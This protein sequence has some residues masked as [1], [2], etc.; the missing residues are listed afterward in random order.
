MRRLLVISFLFFGGWAEAQTL[1]QKLSAA[2]NRLQADSQCSYASVSLT[3]LDAKTGEQVFTGNP[4]MGLATASTLKTITSITAFNMLGPDFQYQTLL[5]YTGELGADGTLNGDIIIK[6]AG[7]PTLGSWRYE[8]T[9]ENRVLATMAQ[10]L[11]KAGIKKITGRIIGDDSLFGTQSIPEGWIWQDIGNYYGA[12]TSGLCWRENQFDIKLRT[13]AVGNPV[14]I[15]R[16]VPSVP[17]LTFKSELTNG[18]AG[19][20]DNAY[21]FLPV[22]SK[23]MYLRG[24]YAIDQD[25]KSISAALPDAAYDAALR[26]NDTL[27]SLGIII[28]AGP[29][30]AVTLSAKNQSVP[31]IAKNLATISSPTLSKIVYWLN[32]KSINLYA[33]QLLKTLAWKQGKKPTTSNGVDVVQQFWQ[34][35]GIDAKSINIY[36]GSGLSPGDRVTTLTLARI[37]QSAKKESW[38]ADLYASLPVYNDMKMKS[39][40][41][42]SVLCYAGYQTKNGREL[43]F[44]IMVNNYSGSSR[45]IKEKI[46]RV[47]DE[48]K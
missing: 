38:F 15:L 47:L 48:L 4:N 12:G 41:I 21:A 14:G 40:S 23:V 34:A 16:T 37:L 3:V 42:N 6:G 45:G 27:R 26:L 2:F 29:E 25:K 8:Q 32:Q 36:D 31:V 39:G 17:Y 33:E 13:G 46:F 9:K 30:S 5:G 43:C 44:S 28:G 20:G 11:Q 22:G 1:Q 10:A 7:D 19:S 18:A 24:T 35:H